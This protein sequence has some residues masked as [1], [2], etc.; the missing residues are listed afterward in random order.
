MLS[1][2]SGARKGRERG[3]GLEDRQQS[4]PV[5]PVTARGEDAK[6]SP[7]LSSSNMT[8]PCLRGHLGHAVFHG[9]N[10]RCGMMIWRKESGK[11]DPVKGTLGAVSKF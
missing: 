5:A 8:P 2:T 6:S 11:C 7:Q 4:A 1:E 9:A 3:R 10:P